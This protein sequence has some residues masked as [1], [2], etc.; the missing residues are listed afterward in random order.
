MEIV[1]HINEIDNSVAIS[2]TIG[3]FDGLHLGHQHLLKLLKSSADKNKTKVAVMTFVP[4][5]HEIL[6][7]SESSYLINTYN[8]RRCLLEAH[9]ADYIIEMPFT[10]D[11]STTTPEDFLEKDI[12]CGPT[13][14]QLIL[15]YDFVFGSNKI[16][17]FDSICSYCAKKNVEVQR[18][19]EFSLEGEVI[20]STMVRNSLCEGDI[21]SANKYLGRN[22]FISGG[23]VKGEGRGRQI[24]FP[25]ANISFSSKRITPERGVY[26]TR[27]N[28]KEMKYC[29]LTNIGLNP[30][31]GHRETLSVETHI[32]DFDKDIYGENIMVDFVKKLRDEKKFN[33]VNDLIVQIKE[34]VVHAKRYFGL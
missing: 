4:H 27:T 13:I 14:S 21:E 20:S 18:Q 29:S 5:P 28:Y 3:N 12:F 10:R 17:N 2:L 15:G 26:I 32:L 24:G 22:Y 31:F 8:E 25:T 19:S 30:T 23:V 6:R 7:P 34:D 33:S 9:G 1:N 16:G 11:F